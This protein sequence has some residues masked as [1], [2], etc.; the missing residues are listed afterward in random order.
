MSPPLER[1]APPT[2]AMN[3]NPGP[4]ALPL[5]V[6]ERAQDELLDFAGTGMSIMEHSHRGKQYEAV[7]DEAIDLLRELMDIPAEYA[8][9]FLQGGASQQFAQVPMNL[10]SSGGS[11]A[12]VLTGSWSEKAYAEA[13][14][15]AALS[16]G[17]VEVAADSGS[18]EGKARSYTRVPRQDEIHLDA[19][20]AY[21]H[22]TS[23]ETIHG[24]EFAVAPG[25]AFPE[26]GGVPVVCDM[27]SDFLWRKLDVSR[28]GLI[29]A[30]AQKNLGPSGVLLAVVRKQLVERGRNDIPAIFQYRTYAQNN[31]LYN[32][33][34]TFAI[35]LVRNVLAWV[36]EQGGLAQIERWNRE[37]ARLI[38]D[39]IDACP[40]F[41]RCPVERE[42]RSAMNV[43]FRLPT[44]ELEDEFVS[45]AAKQ[46]MIGL[47]GHRSVG[48]VRVSL[49][50]AI[51]VEWAS[52]LAEF[53]AD[54]ARR[55]G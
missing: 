1:K 37:K 22:L 36:K 41:Y 24:V 48:G 26:F 18:G 6:L 50:N 32:T 54:F 19:R 7:H 49:Y 29:Y 39:A 45:A 51:P 5:A 20:A 4:A 31:S 2:R 14:T 44:P 13:Q 12:Y 16:S 17:R 27:S 35:Y 33:P 42:S 46:Q 3:F 11:A 21:V 47:K 55:K 38:Y 9:L 30:G 34:P 53:M 15:V 40:E 52:A 25:T 23:N 28:F 8:V 10:L 43:V